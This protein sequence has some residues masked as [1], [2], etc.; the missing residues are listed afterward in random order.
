MEIATADDGTEPIYVRQYT[1]VYSTIKNE[2]ILLDA[3]GNTY[4]PG[5][6]RAEGLQSHVTTGKSIASITSTVGNANI[7]NKLSNTQL[8][9]SNLNNALA[10]LVGGTENER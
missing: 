9:L 4:F 3:S 5:R 7:W 1:G 10:I 8:Y 6:L 2:A